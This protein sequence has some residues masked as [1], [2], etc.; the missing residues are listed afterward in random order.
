MLKR[1]LSEYGQ[2]LGY[3]HVEEDAMVLVLRW[4]SH[5]QDLE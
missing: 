5:G 1:L 4:F 2:L 3:G